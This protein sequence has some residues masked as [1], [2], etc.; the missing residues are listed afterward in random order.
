M[1]IV[2][3]VTPYS[4]NPCVWET[5][6]RMR[7]GTPSKIHIF[8]TSLLHVSFVEYLFLLTNTSPLRFPSS[9]HHHMFSWSRSPLNTY[10]STFWA[11]HCKMGGWLRLVG[12]LKSQV[13]FAEYCLFYRALWQKRPVILSSLL[14]VATS[15][16]FP[17][18]SRHILGSGGELN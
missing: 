3:E 2:T 15:Y 17:L 6:I 11:V 18:C 5:H 9:S 8:N 7:R 10:N 1:A 12:S 13:S 14:I 4:M 16:H